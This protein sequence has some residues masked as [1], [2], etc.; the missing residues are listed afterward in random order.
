MAVQSNTSSD[1]IA[2]PT[3]TGP[4]GAFFVSLLYKATHNPGGAPDSA[5][6]SWENLAATYRVRMTWDDG[7]GA[8]AS[9]TILNGGGGYIFPAAFPA[10]GYGTT[11]FHSFVFGF[12]GTN[13]YSY[14]DG[15]RQNSVA[16]GAPASGSAPISIMEDPYG[17]F[18]TVSPGGQFSQ[19]GVWTGRTTLFDAEVL[20][21][22]AGG[23]PGAIS[24]ASPT[25]LVE[26]L[27]LT[28]NS[29]DLGPNGYTQTTSG[30]PT[31]VADPPF[32][33]GALPAL[34]TP[35]QYLMSAFRGPE[36]SPAS[37]FQ[38]YLFNGTDTTGINFQ[39]RP[40]NTIGTPGGHIIHDPGIYFVNNSLETAQNGTFWSAC[41]NVNGGVESTWDLYKLDADGVTARYVA[42]PDCSS[43]SGVGSNART[44][45]PQFFMDS[46]GSIHIIVCISNDN[47]A[48]MAP[49]EMHPTNAGWTTWSNPVQITGTSLPNKVYD[50]FMQKVGSTYYIWNTN[51]VGGNPWYIDLWA[52][53][54]PF[55]GYTRIQTNVGGAFGWGGDNEGINVV[56][57]ADGRWMIHLDYSFGDGTYY[58]LSPDATFPPVTWSGLTPVNINGLPNT[59]PNFVAQGASVILIPSSTSDAVGAA[60]GTGTL[61]GAG[62]AQKATAG[63]AAGVGA[64]AGAGAAVVASAG[65]ASG[66]GVLAGV[67]GAQAAGMGAAAGAGALLGAGAGVAAAAGAAA[68]TGALTGFAGGVVNAT[69]AAAGSGALAGAGIAQASAVGTAAGAG[70]LTGA[71]TA[72]ASTQGAASGHGTLSGISYVAPS[73][74]RPGRFLSLPRDVRAILLP[75][76]EDDMPPTPPQS[77][78]PAAGTDTDDY[79]LSLALWL[80]PDDTVVNPSVAILSAFAGDTNPL[81]VVPNSVAVD[82]G[83]RRVMVPP[84]I[85]AIDPGPRIQM[86]LTGGTLGRT[87]VTA[88]TWETGSGRGIT[89]QASLFIQW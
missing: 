19:L 16:G 15:V 30:S 50:A 6:F 41:I 27:P 34:N 11:N 88:I 87:Y 36:S 7:A 10:S 33:Q 28:S 76:D 9:F 85:P 17:A 82:T 53:S 56:Q 21:L 81:A 71:G 59:S 57:R 74:A 35:G 46:D 2:S 66:A 24:R 32:L 22:A 62:T 25:A 69:G 64:L 61:T 43:A 38:L 73:T 14:L 54:S 79:W 70:A 49:Y 44:F 60:S 67:G 72:T 20:Y 13:Y 89:R 77:W 1:R 47:W 86:K 39:F 75:P 5:L 45:G 26:Y 52:S 55:S 48:T 83:D 8:K 29:N 51:A 18:G 80:P 42:S 12:D 31:Y 4:T 84:G 23:L 78:S 40:V 37:L 63:A 68:G 3:I 65:V 58:A